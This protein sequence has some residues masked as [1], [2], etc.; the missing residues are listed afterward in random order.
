M[1]DIKYLTIGL[2]Y[3]NYLWIYF[4]FIF[5]KVYETV[6]SISALDC[7]VKIVLNLFAVVL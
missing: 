1:Q 2:D 7:V 6:I 3:K 5:V 4:S